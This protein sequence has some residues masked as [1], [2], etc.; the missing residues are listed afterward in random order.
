MPSWFSTL[1]AISGHFLGACSHARWTQAQG[2]L[3]V[4]FGLGSSVI[5]GFPGIGVKR[6][7]FLT[8]LPTPS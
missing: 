5:R 3:G 2:P 1:T 7:F 4:T 6:T 8:N